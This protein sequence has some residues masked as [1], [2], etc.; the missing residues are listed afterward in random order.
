[1]PS[2]PPPSF[3]YGF[4]S[5]RIF[6]NNKNIDKE[7]VIYSHNTLR[8]GVDSQFVYLHYTFEHCKVTYRILN[9]FKWPKSSLSMEGQVL[10]RQKWEF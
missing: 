7:E 3:L 2:H 4:R 1:M 8:N 6:D 5:L 10:K 9:S